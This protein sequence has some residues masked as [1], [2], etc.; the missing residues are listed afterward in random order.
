MAKAR[1]DAD[2]T[3]KGLKAKGKNYGG[4]PGKDQFLK[5]LVTELRHQDP[6]QPMADKEFVAQ[7]AQFSSLEQMQNI[8]TSMSELNNKAKLSEAYDLIG[9]RVLA[10][11]EE[12]GKKTEGVVTHVLRANG[13]VRLVVSGE[14]IELESIEAVYAAEPKAQREQ[15]I[16]QNNDTANRGQAVRSY[17][18][19]GAPAKQ[20][21]VNISK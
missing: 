6:T 19:A 5:L 13:D 3:N 16:P 18:A 9:K 7:M 4:Q 10:V 2:V 20:Q 14:A 15:Q 11:N 17:D 8:N 21:T 12:T 1:R